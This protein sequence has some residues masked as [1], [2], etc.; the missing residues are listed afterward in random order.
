MIVIDA[1]AMIEALVGDAPPPELL[2]LLGEE[3]LAAPHLLDVEILS[4]MR[5]L[6]RGRRIDAD[7]AHDAGQTY[8]S[9]TIARYETAMLAERIWE[10]RHRC[11]AYDAGYLA[12][13]EL[14]EVPLVT[15]DEKLPAVGST[16]DIVLL[17]ALAT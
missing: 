5:S 6:E 3:M 8:F 1:S 4:V 11:T 16:A 13:A 10:L 2:S 12:L 14:L 15:A 17:D 9:L 7:R